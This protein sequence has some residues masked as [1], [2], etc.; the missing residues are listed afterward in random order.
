M[1]NAA[2][3]SDFEMEKSDEMKEEKEDEKYMTFD[4]APR[5]DAIREG[6]VHSFHI[7]AR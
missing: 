5:I 3:D 4:T 7:V 6:S 1:A 2:V